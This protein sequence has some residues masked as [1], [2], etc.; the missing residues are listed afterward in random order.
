MI[1]T[2]DYARFKKIPAVLKMTAHSRDRLSDSDWQLAFEFSKVAELP[3]D[4]ADYDFSPNILKAAGSLNYYVHIE[5]L[6]AHDACLEN[7]DQWE[8]KLSQA[9][10]L[11]VASQTLRAK[12]SAYKCARAKRGILRRGMPTEHFY[13]VVRAIGQCL[14]FG[15]M[16]EAQTLVDLCGGVFDNRDFT[17][18][19][20][21]DSLFPPQ[22]AR[23]MMVSL[24][25][26]APSEF[27]DTVQ[28]ICK[29]HEVTDWVAQNWRTDDTELLAE[30]LRLLCVRH[31]HQSRPDSSKV[32]YEFSF[33]EHFYDIYEVLAVLRMR[34]EN[35][36][37]IPVVSHPLMET[38]LGVLVDIEKPELPV[39]VNAMLEKCNEIL[40]WE[41]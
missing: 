32:W 7:D 40:S 17:D 12:V 30:K 29:K 1:D 28:A 10:A 27:S 8:L 37:S 38:K 14:R 16:N 26:P 11:L 9:A 36:L 5:M 20:N 34:K 24:L 39:E 25:E 31:T 2:T 23:S 21:D 15:W 19:K 33:I 3:K 18:L 35:G 4:Q 6:S 41:G 22:Q 13:Q